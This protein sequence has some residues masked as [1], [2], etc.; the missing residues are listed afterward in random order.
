MYSV[1]QITN[2]QK[3]NVIASTAY[4]RSIKQEHKVSR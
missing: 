3:L 1:T 4:H 2:N